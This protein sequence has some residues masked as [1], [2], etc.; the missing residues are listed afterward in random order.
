MPYL[1]RNYSVVYA[2]HVFFVISEYKAAPH[3]F[4][5]RKAKLYCKWALQ[6]QIQNTFESLGSLIVTVSSEH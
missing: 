1:V 4:I 2:V 5:K 3:Y 6:V